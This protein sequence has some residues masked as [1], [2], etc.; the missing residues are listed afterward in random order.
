ME[1]WRGGGLRHAVFR[2]ETLQTTQHRHLLPPNPNPKNRANSKVQDWT[3]LHLWPCMLRIARLRS[4]QHGAPGSKGGS[5]P[6]L[7]SLKFEHLNPAW[8]WGG[9]TGAKRATDQARATGVGFVWFRVERSGWT[10]EHHDRHH[11]SISLPCS[12]EPST[13][14]PKRP[15]AVSPS[16]LALDPA[17]LR[18]LLG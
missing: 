11:H 6:P 7:L 5:P 3:Y 16:L 15:T 9:D 4:Q 18:L 13:Q 8:I 17:A 2:D 1:S 14:D 10:L 12:R